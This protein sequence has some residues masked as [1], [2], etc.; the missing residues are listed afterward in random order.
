[1]VHSRFWTRVRSVSSKNLAL[2]MTTLVVGLT[3]TTLITR[4]I[5]HSATELS[6]ISTQSPG[7]TA[8]SSTPSTSSATSITQALT[9]VPPRSSEPPAAEAPHHRRVDW[10]NVPAW[11]GS[12]LSGL[13]VI[14]AISIIWRDRMQ[15]IRS[16]AAKV[17][18]WEERNESGSSILYLRNT[19]D[20]PI[21]RL[22]LLIETKNRGKITSR[23]LS[24]Y[25]ADE[26]DPQGSVST[27][28]DARDSSAV[29]V[30]FTGA[31]NSVWER[32]VHSGK[33]KRTKLD[34]SVDEHRQRGL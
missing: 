23:L 8:L 31:D 6:R 34:T 18:I 17:V 24:A 29:R 32:D 9:P 21:F 26:V 28:I 15:R 12:L 13:S 11:V 16:Q 10:G 25:D 20:M 27:K 7:A 33:L 22:R 30:R 3:I 4:G 19:S 2:A 5:T 1:M 14:L